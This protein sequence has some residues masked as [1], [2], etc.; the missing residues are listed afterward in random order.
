MHNL[1]LLA[2]KGDVCGPMVWN[3][4]GRKNVGLEVSPSDEKNPSIFVMTCINS[5]IRH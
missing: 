2:S 4:F 3:Y 5:T 1:M